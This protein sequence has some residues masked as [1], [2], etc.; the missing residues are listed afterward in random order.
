MDAGLGE[1]NR[2]YRRL[3][4]RSKNHHIL[5]S[6]SLGGSAAFIYAAPIYGSVSPDSGV[7]LVAC[8]KLEQWANGRK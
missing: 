1:H 5:V 8:I 3:Q 2:W 7:K 6:H 4:V